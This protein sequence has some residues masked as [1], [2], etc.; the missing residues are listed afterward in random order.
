MISLKLLVHRVTGDDTTLMPI[1]PLR[2]LFATAG[3]DLAL[4]EIPNSMSEDPTDPQGYQDAMTRILAGRS[5]VPGE[6]ANLIIGQ[7]W[8]G[9][10]DTRA[11][12]MLVDLQRRGFA[13]V[14]TR[15][16]HL[17]HGGAS[18]LLRTFAH[19][20]GHMLNLIHAD[21]TPTV[22]TVE[23]QAQ[24]QDQFGNAFDAAW[25][26]LGTARPPTVDAFPFGSGERAWL[27]HAIP[28]DIAPWG[29]SFFR[30]S[31]IA[32]AQDLSRPTVAIKL[33][34]VRETFSVGT[35]VFFDVEIKNVGEAP[36]NIP[37]RL[38][39]ELGN[40]RVVITDPDGW[41]R[42]HQPKFKACGGGLT[43]LKPGDTLIQAQCISHH[44]GGCV[45]PAP[46]RY[47]LQGSSPISGV[48]VPHVEIQA[49]RSRSAGGAYFN[50]T[51]FAN[52]IAAGFLPNNRMLLAKVDHILRT[53]RPSG[54][55][56]IPHLALLRA[57]TIKDRKRREELLTLAERPGSPRSVRHAAILVRAAGMTVDPKEFLEFASRM[58]DVLEPRDDAPILEWLNVT[59]THLARRDH[60][61]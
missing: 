1:G 16:Y 10:G 20:I 49:K 27:T 31:D 5:P 57:R 32:G 61:G 58:A 6:P 19:E 46:G 59:R 33:V 18:A 42:E 52:S 14:F 45:L 25:A 3:I 11:N 39:P 51:R 60:S 24:V 2:D 41:A 29:T 50:E 48:R 12:G 23:C 30:D 37:S 38:A 9:P 44:S 47:K 34:P 35:P 7:N 4:Q 36:I 15:S 13:A 55:P 54:S 28:D 43:E 26:R 17:A 53:S 56:E 21:G 22:P 8:A 40:L